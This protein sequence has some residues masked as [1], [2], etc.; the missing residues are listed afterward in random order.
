M[1]SRSRGLGLWLTLQSSAEPRENSKTAYPTQPF[2]RNINNLP[3]QRPTN[4]QK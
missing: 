4:G 3:V 2:A 1:H